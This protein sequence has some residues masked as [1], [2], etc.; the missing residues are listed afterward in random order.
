MQ[1]FPEKA[2]PH[3][4]LTVSSYGASINKWKSGKVSRKVL[5]MWNKHTGNLGDAQ[6][7]LNTRTSFLALDLL[8]LADHW[9]GN[10]CST[11]TVNSSGVLV[12]LWHSD[13][14]QLMGEMRVQIWALNCCN[15]GQ[16]SILYPV[17]IVNMTHTSMT[18]CHGNINCIVLGSIAVNSGTTFH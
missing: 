15:S 2:W 5:R 7:P 18:Q 12:Q 14:L 10:V 6:L 17:S 3:T 9:H 11:V 1:Q 16:Q 13:A 4:Q 8:L